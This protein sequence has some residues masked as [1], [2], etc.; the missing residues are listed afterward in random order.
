MR[1]RAS[2]KQQ[3]LTRVDERLGRCRRVGRPRW[4]SKVSWVHKLH[5]VRT[6]LL[7][8]GRWGSSPSRGLVAAFAMRRS[9]LGQV[10]QLR[11]R[12]VFC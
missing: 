6:L 10:N 5:G 1:W 12:L 7:L 8:G 4:R 11:G 9:M 3:V 2:S